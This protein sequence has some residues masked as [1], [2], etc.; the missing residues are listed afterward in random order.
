MEYNIDSVSLIYY[1]H[2]WLDIVDI[3]EWIERQYNTT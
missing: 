2:K 3:F 1:S